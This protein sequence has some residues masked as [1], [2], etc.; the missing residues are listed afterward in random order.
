MIKVEVL[1]ILLGLLIGIFI[2][3]ATSGPPKIVFKYPTVDNI[4]NTTYIDENGICYRY[5][6]KEIACAK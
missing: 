5:Y 1:Y 3:Y 2:I 6:A 4:K